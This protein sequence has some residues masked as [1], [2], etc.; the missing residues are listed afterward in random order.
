MLSPCIK[1]LCR[2]VAVEKHQRTDKGSEYYVDRISQPILSVEGGLACAN[3]QTDLCPH[4]F[5]QL[6][7]KIA[8]EIQ[9]SLHEGFLHQHQLMYTYPA[10]STCLRCI[11]CMM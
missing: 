10:A 9:V 8:C 6:H 2:C 11:E 3:N 5:H 7:H 4:L 1:M